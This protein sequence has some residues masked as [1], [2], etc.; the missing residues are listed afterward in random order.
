[1]KKVW[2][3]RPLRVARRVGYVRSLRL[4][5]SRGCKGQS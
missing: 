3:L 1:L 2:Y 4:V 5:Q